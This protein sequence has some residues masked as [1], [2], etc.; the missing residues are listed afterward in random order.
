VSPAPVPSAR[1]LGV[2]RALVLALTVALLGIFVLW[3]L[4]RF[5]GQTA[6]I[7]CTLA[8][9]P[10]LLAIPA[11]RRGAPEVYLGALLLTT[12]YLGY[13]LMEVL[14]N[15]GARPFAAATVFVSF[16]LAVALVAALRISRR[17]AA[18]PT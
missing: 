7:A 3:H 1:A 13:A 15:P 4:A 5:S 8:V 9:G 6:L 11:F 10:W 18:A 2:A 16:A 17:R 12:P 14:A